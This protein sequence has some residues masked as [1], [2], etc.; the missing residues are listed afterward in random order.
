[1]ATSPINSTDLLNGEIYNAAGR[2]RAAERYANT[3]TYGPETLNGAL[4][5]CPEKLRGRHVHM[6]GGVWVAFCSECDAH[7]RSWDSVLL[8]HPMID[9]LWDEHG[10]EQG[11]LLP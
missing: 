6:G 7:L 5:K 4:T 1:M 3:P 2:A 11:P 9:H 10:I 8:M